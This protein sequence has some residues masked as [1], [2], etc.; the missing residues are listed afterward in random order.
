MIIMQKTRKN[1]NQLVIK[2]AN[3]IKLAKIVKIL[4]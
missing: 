1:K 4:T 3:K 2:N